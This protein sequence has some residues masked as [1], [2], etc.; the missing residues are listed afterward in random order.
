MKHL[1]VGLGNIGAQY[2]GTR[3]NIGFTIVDHIA[4]QKAAPFKTAHLGLLAE[5]SQKKHHIRLLKPTTY[6]NLSG[7]AVHYWLRQLQIPKQQLLIITD[8]INLPLGKLRLRPKGSNSVSRA[9]S[10]NRLAV[11]RS[12]SLRFT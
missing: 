8:D 10:K 2:D 1:V 12:P 9:D 6:M 4:N 11:S 3:H 7:Q 5:I